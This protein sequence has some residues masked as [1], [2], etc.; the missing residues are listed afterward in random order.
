MINGLIDRLI[1]E[2]VMS[3]KCAHVCASRKGRPHRGGRG[4]RLRRT[5]LDEGVNSQT[6]C[7]R[8]VYCT[9]FVLGSFEVSSSLIG[10]KQFFDV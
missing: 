2:R 7:S 5:V 4:S 6:C 8:T 3:S 1:G 9:A 10:C